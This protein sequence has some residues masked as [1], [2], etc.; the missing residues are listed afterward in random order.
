[1]NIDI[2]DIKKVEEIVNMPDPLKYEEWQ[3]GWKQSD[4]D[5]FQMGIKQGQ[6]ELAK[7]VREALI[8]IACSGVIP[9]PPAYSGGKGLI[10]E[11]YDLIEYLRKGD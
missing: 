6:M 4:R 2:Y 10:R 1:M 9:I 8:P 3:N 11:T 5:I 7:D